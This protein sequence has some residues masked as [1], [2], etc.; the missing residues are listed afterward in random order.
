MAIAGGTFYGWIQE[1]LLEPNDLGV[2]YPSGLWTPDEVVDYTQRRQQEL[3]SRVRVTVAWEE[4]D[5]TANVDQLTLPQDWIATQ[6]VLLLQAGRSNPLQ[7]ADATQS[8]LLAGAG[9]ARPVA[10]DDATQAP[11]Q[12]RLTPM[13]DANAA[14]RLLYLSLPAPLPPAT[15][16]L[17]AVPDPFVLYVKY[18]VLAD[19]LNKVGRG[20][21]LQRA[22]YCT[23]R[24]EEGVIAGSI[25][26]GGL[27]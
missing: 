13:P 20:Q 23:A 11:L 14:L 2:S 7:P 27:F 16:E 19:C 10:Y 8:D 18:G 24:F 3:I 5:V 22:S 4:L 6:S 17:F 26:L 12:L 21:D 15:A 9:P 1:A 25:L